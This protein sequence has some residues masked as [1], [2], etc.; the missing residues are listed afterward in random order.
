MRP[1][2]IGAVGGDGVLAGGRLRGDAVGGGPASEAACRH[3]HTANSEDRVTRLYRRVMGADRCSAPRCA[4]SSWP[5]SCV[6]LLASMRARSASGCVKVKM[7]PFDNKS[8]FQIII[9]MPE[10]TA[11]E[12]TA[13]VAGELAAA[14]LEAAR[15]GRISRRTSAPRRLQLQRPG[16][17]LLSAPRAERRRHPGQPAWQR[18]AQAAEPRDRQA[19]ARAPA[20]HRRSVTARAS[21]SP[22]SA[23]AAGAA[24]AGRR[25]LRARRRTAASASRARFAISSKQ[26]DGVVDVD[27]YVEDDSRSTRFVR[28][29][30]R[31]P[32][33]TASPSD[34]VARTVH[35][36]LGRISGRPAAR[37]RREGR[38]ADHGA[39]RRATRSDLERFADLQLRG[40]G[41]TWWR[42]ASSRASTA[43]SR[44]RASTTRT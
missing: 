19:R 17:P 42:S 33:S 8:E 15:G 9:D 22:R 44:T 27:W 30:A 6:L 24:D 39:P 23:R 20:A 40:R 13:R 18:R 11:L 12:E 14:T 43:P 3:T 32:R 4:R 25:S 2:P 7:L 37:R 34:D 26:T 29:P 41:G 31:K 28:R 38:R 5:A 10:G 1:I 35:G 36:S 16:A 21:R